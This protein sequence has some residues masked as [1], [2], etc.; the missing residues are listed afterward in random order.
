LKFWTLEPSTQPWDTER[1]CGI[2]NAAKLAAGVTDRLWEVSDLVAAWEA[3]ERRE[4]IAA[5]IAELA[6]AASNDTSA[7]IQTINTMRSLRIWF[8]MTLT[9]SDV[10]SL[11][12]TLT[13]WEYAEYASGAF[14][15]IA[16]VGEYISSFKP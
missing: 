6:C 3:E 13:L 9:P 8:K 16:C 1:A 2:R 10:A 5:S 7:N 15:A 12:S 14:V 11:T 4:E